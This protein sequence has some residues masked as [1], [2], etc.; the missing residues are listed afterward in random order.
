MTTT[1]DQRR[2][3]GHML[4]RESEGGAPVLAGYAATWLDEYQLRSDLFERFARGAFTKT[5]SE[6][7][8]IV[9]LWNHDSNLPLASVGQEGEQLRLAEDDVGL[10]CVIPLMDT[11]QHRHYAQLVATKRVS[12][13]SHGFSIRKHEQ[14]RTKDRVLNTITDVRLYEV[15]PVVFPANPDTEIGVKRAIEAYEAL[16]AP[17][18]R[19]GFAFLPGKGLVSWPKKK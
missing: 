16:Q 19:R 2:C 3:R 17:A 4:T 14:E 11:E 5:L 8:D 1:F 10:H 9:S 18:P 13:M 12:K 6:D 7:R 15:S